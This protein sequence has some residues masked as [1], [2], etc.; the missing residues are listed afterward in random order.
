MKP[1]WRLPPPLKARVCWRPRALWLCLLGLGF[2]LLTWQSSL[3][4]RPAPLVHGRVVGQDFV[5]AHAALRSRRMADGRPLPGRPAN[6]TGSVAVVIVGGGIA[7]LVAAWELQKRGI[8][9]RLLEM[10]GEVGGN[11]RSGHDGPGGVAYPW[12]AH[13]VPVPPRRSVAVRRLFEELGIMRGGGRRGSS[14]NGEA[15]EADL[16][17]LASVCAEPAERM[18]MPNTGWRDRQDGL[19]PWE[20]MGAED[21]RQFQRFRALVDAETNRKTADGRR[22]FTVPLDECSRD[23]KARELDAE[24]MGFWLAR[25][26]FSS[27]PLYWFV[28][29]ATRDDYGASLNDTSAWAAL[30]YF[31]SRETYTRLEWPEG[32]GYFVR[33]LVDRVRASVVTDALVYRIGRVDEHSSADGGGPSAALHVHFLLDHSSRSGGARAA[34][35]VAQRVIF[36]APIFSAARI[37][38]GWNDTWPS[39]F[40]YAPWLVANLHLRQR[41]DGHERCDNVIFRSPALGY[42][43]SRQQ[44]WL[45]GLGS[46]LGLGRGVVITYYR[47]LH[48]ASPANGRRLLASRSWKSWKDEI[49]ADLRQAHP[50][51]DTLLLRLDVRLLGHAMVRPTPGLIWGGARAAACAARPLGRVHFAHSDLSA[52]PL[53]EEAV[54]WGARVAA[55]V[56]LLI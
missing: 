50:A 37:I 29:Y 24:S 26:G 48:E 40:T 15:L 52:L 4:R 22:P 20:L 16:E 3:V 27:A 38:S 14:A 56:S 28:E 5:S 32:N 42:T 1:P 13:Y 44:S 25:H 45:A 54:Y 9:F 31:G 19:V 55:E 10:E 2:A 23:G 43:I 17:A 41:P 51:I 18:H 53:F 30:H 46:M 35:V 7:G 11:A 47:A 8:R 12:G 39:Q 6:E 34:S 36:A 49:L 33:R 21:Q